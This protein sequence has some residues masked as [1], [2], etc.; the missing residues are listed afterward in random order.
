MRR[1]MTLSLID[2]ALLSAFNL[3]LSV[4]LIRFAS[5]AEFGLFSYVV[6]VLMILSSVHNA[7]VATPI[8]V[9][10]PGRPTETKKKVLSVLLRVDHLL[11]GALLAAAAL[12]V[13]LVSTDVAF[14]AAAASAC[15]FWLWRETHRG[16]AFADGD[17]ARALRID[18][19]AVLV[20][21]AAVAALWRVFPPTLSALSGIAIGNALAVLLQ[22]TR[23]H[24]RPIAQAIADY[25]V[26]WREARWSLFGAATTEAQFRGYVFAVQSF[27][28]ADAL[29]HV[30]AGRTL[31]GPLPL[32]ASAWARVARPA[33]N[34]ALTERRTGDAHRTL[35]RGTL[36]VLGLSVV[37]LAALYLA[38][39]LVETH[40][41]QGRYPDIGIITI[42][43][44]IAT[45]FSVSHI[46]LGTYLQAARRFRPLAFV[47]LAA[48]ACSGTALLVLATSVP[49]FYAIGA[50]AIGEFVALVYTLVLIFWQPVRAADPLEESLS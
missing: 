1:A 20:S 42:A 36:G 5:P 32:L 50:V 18:T 40:L 16:I 14:L 23:H 19:V 48:A 25:G 44:G 9:S 17:A 10:I 22:G 15:F 47:S 4:L 46:C 43:W 13:V 35:W 28:G 41:Y 33:M 8:S 6:A 37:Y 12:L 26:F 24:L 31:M 34:H 21:I 38:W 7:L 29:G 27:R 3:G 2:Q 30:Q 11:R 45:F 49:V 39:P